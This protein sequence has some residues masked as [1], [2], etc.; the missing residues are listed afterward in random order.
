[1]VRRVWSAFMMN[2]M[3]LNFEDISCNKIKSKSNKK[4]ERGE[5]C[6][7]TAVANG[8]MGGLMNELK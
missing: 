7:Q 1:M 4:K 2:L 8:L 5:N 6:V 3:W